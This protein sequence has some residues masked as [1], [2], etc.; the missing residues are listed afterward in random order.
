MA[1]CAVIDKTTNI[2]VNKIVAEVTDLPP[3][4]CFLIDITGQFVD[5]GWFWDGSNF[6]N[7]T[8]EESV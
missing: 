6:I 5:I 7:P 3:D 2:V 4:N 1:D 8:P